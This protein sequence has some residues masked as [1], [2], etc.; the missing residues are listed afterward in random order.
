MGSKI[1]MKLRTVTLLDDENSLL[2]PES[3]GEL[4]GSSGRQQPRRNEADLDAVLG[5]AGDGFADGTGNGAPRDHGK[6]TGS[7][8][9]R[10]MVAVVETLQLVAT[11][12]E[13]DLMVRGA[14]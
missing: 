1:T 14:A 10:P 11:L 9:T 4:F 13:L 6:I 5:G 2:A 3:G 12:V 8:D 7:L